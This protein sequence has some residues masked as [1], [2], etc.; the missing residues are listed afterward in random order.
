MSLGLRTVELVQ[1]IRAILPAG[2]VLEAGM[3]DEI[4]LAPFASELV[5]IAGAVPKR[6][7]EFQAGRAYARKALT[8]LAKAPEPILRDFG[9]APIWPSGFVGSISHTAELCGAVVAKDSDV[10]T[11]GLDLENARDLEPEIIP[12]VCNGQ[13][14]ARAAF[15]L[16]LP[17]G[18]AAMALFSIKE[19]V[20]KAYWPVAGEFLD[21]MDVEINVTRPG[22]FTASVTNRARLGMHGQRTISGHFGN[23]GGVWF[24]LAA[25]P[26]N[27]SAIV[28]D[29]QLCIG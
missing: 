20:Y 3:I 12:M 21:F 25:L 13:E 27:H 11:I 4:D 15:V 8:V 7:K 23:A 17:F 1:A 14:L 22:N 6:R 10:T 28:S 2:T 24:G 18:Q 16:N 5:L 19:S 29:H 9:R 26:I